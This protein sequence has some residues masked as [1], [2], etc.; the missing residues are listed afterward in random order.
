MVDACGILGTTISPYL[1]F[2]QASEEV[3]EEKA[4]GQVTLAMRRGASVRELEMRNIDV[5]VGGFFWNMVMFFIILTTAIT[6]NRHGLTH[7]QATRD[8]AEAAAGRE[9]R[10]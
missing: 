2:W 6:L 5:G 8:A 3:E 4:A 7:I 1:F 10:G 9:V